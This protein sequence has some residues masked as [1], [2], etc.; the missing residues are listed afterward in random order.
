MVRKY[1]FLMRDAYTNLRVRQGEN[2]NDY[3][4]RLVPIGKV[5]Y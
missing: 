3:H 2:E 1:N 4:F 5:A